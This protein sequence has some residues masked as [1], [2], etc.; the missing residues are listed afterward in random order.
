MRSRAFQWCKGPRTFSLNAMHRSSF[1]ALC[2]PPYGGFRRLPTLL[3]GAAIGLAWA[4]GHAQAGDASAWATD[5]HS[6]SRL[7][8]SSPAAEAAARGL[9]AGIEISLSPGWKTYWRYP[10]DS[11]VPPRVDF[12]A[13]RNLKDAQILWPAPTRFAEAD[14]VSIGYPTGVI[15]PLRVQPAD[16]AL[17]VVLRAKLDYAVCKQLCVPVDAQFELEL[18]TRPTA[19][20]DA[21]AVSEALVPK[22]AALGTAEP[23]GVVAVQR[24]SEPEPHV[25]VDV[26]APAG[27]AV[28]LFVEGPDEHW[29][30]PVPIPVPE[31]PAGTRRFTFKLEGMPAD[32]KPQ[33]ARLTY[34]VVSAAG[35]VEVTAPLD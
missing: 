24:K 29:S 31:A 30:L 8:A 19:F 16:P 9:R 32:T 28:D 23:V 21:L 5:Q 22:R 25:V 35:S 33:G 2:V 3:V 1:L 27:V 11:G 18:P 10:G 15:L 17:P 26:R 20:E 6:K 13:S 12:S 7:I 4:G 14:G 34:T